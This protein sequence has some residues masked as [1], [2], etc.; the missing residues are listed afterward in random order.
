MA[1]LREEL[2]TLE[3]KYQDKYRNALRKNQDVLADIKDNEFRLENECHGI[4][5]LES[6]FRFWDED[7]NNN[8]EIFS[9]LPSARAWTSVILAGKC[10]SRRH[11]TTSFS[12]IVE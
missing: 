3:S 2:S 8:N 5:P 10:A 11:S 12:E 4:D 9:I 1:T 6:T 7:D